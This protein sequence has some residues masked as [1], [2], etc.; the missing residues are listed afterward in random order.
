MAGKSYSE[1][2]FGE[3]MRQCVVLG[4]HNPATLRSRKLAAE[5]LLNRKVAVI[6][7]R[8]RHHRGLSRF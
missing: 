6:N 4:L 7:R 3:F 1:A 5:Q 8:K 2:S